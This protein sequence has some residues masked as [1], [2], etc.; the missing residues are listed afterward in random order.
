[1]KRVVSVSLG[2]SQRDHR[3]KI[4]LLGQEVEVERLGTDGSMK[5]AISLIKE[6]DGKVDALGIGGIDLYLCAGGR[7]YPI[8]DGKRLAKAARISPITDGSG[9]KNTLESRTV[10]YLRDILN[11]DLGRKKV[12]IVSG[13]D[14]F[15]MA[16]SFTEAGSQTIF[17]DL[18]F[19]LGIPIPIK[20]LCNLARVASIIAPAVSKLPFSLLYPTGKRQEQ[21]GKTGLENLYNSADI[22]AGDYLYIQKY[23]PQFLPGK[24]ILTNTVTSRDVDDLKRRGVKQLITT[25]PHLDGRSFGTNVIEG[26]VLALSGKRAEQLTQA[27]YEQLLDRFNFRPWVKNLNQTTVS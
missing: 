14:R 26:I 11:L 10:F 21:P 2:S 13:L 12:L 8:R 18:I 3:V 16:R 17:G 19:G 23:M 7:R 25:T 5:K 9:L 15:G 1:M 20:T 24:I 4:S 22:I 27:D 6:L